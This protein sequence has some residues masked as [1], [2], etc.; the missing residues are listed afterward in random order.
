MCV[1]SVNNNKKWV[2]LT[3]HRKENLGS[4][5]NEVFKS[6]IKLSLR[7]DTEIIFP[8][9]P[10]P[11]VRAS[12]EK[13]LGTNHNVKLVKPFNYFEMIWMLSKSSLLITDSGGL[14]KEAP[15]FGVTTVVTRKT[16]ER[17]EAI[18]NGSAFLVGTDQEKILSQTN[19]ILDK[20]IVIKPSFPFGDGLASI[21]IKYFLDLYLSYDRDK[22]ADVFKQKNQHFDLVIQE[23]EKQDSGQENK[24]NTPFEKISNL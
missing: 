20:E 13:L 6:A 9:H 24:F 7:S 5:L 18:E 2:I 12:I 4:G 8:V 19:S 22:R 11:K 3:G 21:R 10:N 14:Q 1:T 15:F 16:T 17:S 23:F